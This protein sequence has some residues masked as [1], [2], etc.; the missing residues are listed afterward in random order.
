MVCRQANRSASYIEWAEPRAIVLEEAG[1]ISGDVNLHSGRAGRARIDENQVKMS[2][3]G[4]STPVSREQEFAGKLALA[5]TK[6]DAITG[7]ER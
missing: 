6:K 7:R 2:L 3:G 5:Y 4:I 1:R